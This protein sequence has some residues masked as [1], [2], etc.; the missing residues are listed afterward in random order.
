MKLKKISGLFLGLGLVV[1]SNSAM[2]H[3]LK[4]KTIMQANGASATDVW[5]VE[6]LGDPVVG[7]THKLVAEIKEFT[8]ASSSLLSLVVFKD[9]KA[10]STTDLV[11]GDGD[12]SPQISVAAGNG[13]Y[14]MIVTHTDTAFKVY[15]I[16]YHCENA[17]GDHTP[18]TVP[19]TPVQ[20]Q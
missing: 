3:D 10:Q 11:A 7:N 19:T 1:G 17:T 6:C 8:G 12:Y 2:A 18:T 15:D 13:I 20:D 9:G 16:S 5:Q 14:N 4:F